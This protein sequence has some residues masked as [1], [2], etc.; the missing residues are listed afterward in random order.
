M[1]SA[2]TYSVR[3]RLDPAFSHS[4]RISWCTGWFADSARATGQC[5][6]SLD[7]WA[8]EEHTSRQVRPGHD[9]PPG[10]AWPP[11]M[12]RFTQ[13]TVLVGSTT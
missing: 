13:R 2:V 4:P 6:H 1:G 7:P 12:V 5:S 10:G 9:P 11:L 8:N 3:A